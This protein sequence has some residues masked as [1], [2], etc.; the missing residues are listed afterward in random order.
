MNDAQRIRRL[1]ILVLSNGVH[2]VFAALTGGSTI[3]LY[4]NE[5]GLDKAQIGLIG[6]LIHVFGPIAFLFGPLAMRMGLKRAGIL[7]FGFRK[8]TITL[9]ALAPWL[10]VHYSSSVV[11]PFIVLILV[12]YG[13][14]RVL[15]E[16]ALYPWMLEVIPNSVRGQF[17]AFSGMASTACA[18]AG[19]AIASHVIA[20]NTGFGRFQMLILIGG[21][22]G[23]VSVLLLLFLPGGEPKKE[24]TSRTPNWRE[25]RFA[26][27]DRNL[28]AYIL[29]L[30]TAILPT[31]AWAIFVPLYL[32]Q[33][34]GIEAAHVVMLQSASIAGHFCSSYIWGWAADHFGS[35]PVALSGLMLTVAAPLGWIMMPHHSVWSLPCAAAIALVYGVA[36]IA[37]EIGLKRLLYAGIVPPEKRLEYIAI[38]YSAQEVT[39]LS[40][41]LLAGLLLTWLDGAGST[42]FGLSSYT[43]YFALT[44]TLC[45]V[46]ILFVRRIKDDGAVSTLQLW[47]RL[48]GVYPEIKER[49]RQRVARRPRR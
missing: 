38:Y 39:L 6:S 12:T 1:P 49:V 7:F 35:K 5:L 43:V 16:T 30:C 48:P 13:I 27:G 31:T 24:Q 2:A 33:E 40:S 14:A 29:G 45:A 22:I 3:I 20:S 10:A 37:W 44:M 15:A 18:L 26:L 25:L 8:V 23:V 32:L 46:S 17:E 36:S 4:Y 9:L 41:P 42:V 34:V 21:A 19:I 28:R 11:F 47:A